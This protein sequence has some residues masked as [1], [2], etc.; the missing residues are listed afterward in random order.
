[1]QRQ[2]AE[3]DTKAKGKLQAGPPRQAIELLSRGKDGPASNDNL[4]SAEAFLKD[5]V[6]GPRTRSK[7]KAVISQMTIDQFVMML[8]TDV[9]SIELA[10][11]DVDL[12]EFIDTRK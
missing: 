6:Q 4:Q 11:D 1:M 2:Q 3:A 7:G 12:Y 5:E 8:H 9:E 10:G